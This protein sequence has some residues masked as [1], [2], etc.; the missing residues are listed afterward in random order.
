MEKTR[1]CVVGLGYIGLPTASLLATMG[2]RVHGVDLNTR[3]VDTI[4]RGDVHIVEPDLDVMVRS[5]V[6]SGRLQ[7]STHPVEAEIFILALPTPLGPENRPDI[8]FVEAGTRAIAP[9]VAPGNLVVLESTSPV[10]TTEKVARWLAEERPDLVLPAARASNQVQIGAQKVFVAHC[11]ERV[12]PGQIL[13]EL[14]DNDRI[15]GGIDEASGHMARE[16]YG[17]FVGGRILVTD[18]RT[19]EMAKLTENAFRDVNIAFANELAVICEHLGI[20]VWKLIELANHHPRVNILRP[21]PGVGGHCIPIDPWFII[22]ASGDDAKLLRAAREVNRLRPEQVAT[23]VA[24]AASEI[25]S[26]TIALLGLAYKNDI[27]DLRESP[28]IQVAR[29]LA[30][31]EVGE[32]IAVEPHIERLSGDLASL[33]IELTDLRTALDRADAVVAL[34]GHRDFRKIRPADLRGKAVVDACGLFRRPRSEAYV[35]S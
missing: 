35:G 29:H 3:I 8:S 11:P 23:K 4:N 33:G 16:F 31:W 1:V 2:F 12:L 34:V 20:D 28:S 22:D 18:A 5:A 9:Y 13:K 27:D 25:D 30:E 21:G 7:A 19:A 26:P 24:A 14:V 32:L 17:G 6:Q 10:G 15:V